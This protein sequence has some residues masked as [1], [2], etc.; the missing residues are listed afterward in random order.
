MNNGNTMNKPE[1]QIPLWR[2]V[3]ASRQ[4]YK[5]R[6]VDPEWLNITLLYVLD[7]LDYVDHLE[8][9]LEHKTTTVTVD[10]Y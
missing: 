2:I 5:G 7:L 9:K 8:N 6:N 3:S 1:P 4:Q 10:K